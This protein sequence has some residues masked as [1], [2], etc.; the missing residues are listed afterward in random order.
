ME[1]FLDLKKKFKV[2]HDMGKIKSLRKGTTGIGYTFEMLLG[3]KED[4]SPA[5]DY[6]GIE[7]KC[8]S[9]LSKY[10]LGLFTCNPKRNDIVATTYIFQKYSYHLY[11][12]PNL[13][14]VFSRKLYADYKYELYNYSFKLNVNYLE[15]KI[16]LESYYKNEFCE[17]V[18]FWNFEDLRNILCN[19]LNK[20]AVVTGY[21]YKED[22][23]IYY[24]YY[25]IKFYVFKNFDTFIKLIERG[26]IYIVSYLRE[27]VNK[28]GDYK[29][30]NRGFSFRIKINNVEDLFYRV[31]VRD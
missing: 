3:K 18:C 11:E 5:P 7:I 26:K 28:L 9:G 24:K 25:S 2:I 22:G 1:E 4:Q 27:D 31:V 21:S 19:K 23:E 17:N 13:Y 6:K 14:R 12:N 10:D 8:R 15:G 29:I 16:Y 30:L 20:L